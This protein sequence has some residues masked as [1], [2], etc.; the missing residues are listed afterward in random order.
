MTTPADHNL[1]D[2]DLRES[3]E[4]RT[5]LSNNESTQGITERTGSRVENLGGGGSVTDHTQTGQQE[6]RMKEMTGQKWMGDCGL[7]VGD[8]EDE[9][10]YPDENNSDGTC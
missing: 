3:V 9:R 5:A 7:E 2:R 1:L 8:S 6:L 4:G 10:C